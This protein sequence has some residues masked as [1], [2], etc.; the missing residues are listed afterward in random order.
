MALN[1]NNVQFAEKDPSKI[2]NQVITLIES[3]LSEEGEL[4]VKLARSDPRRLLALGFIAG[5][6][7]A[8][9]N[10]DFTG[11]MNLLYYATGDYLDHIGFML[12][13]RRLEATAAVTTLRFELSEVL[14]QAYLIPEGTRATPD[15]KQYFVTE[16]IAE[17]PAGESYIDIPARCMTAG[18]VGNGWLEGQIN[19]LVDRLAWVQK[20]HNTTLSTGGTDTEDDENLRTRI[21][22]AP[23]SFSVAGA[24]GAYEYWA[25]T[26]HQN[27]VDVAVLGPPDTEPGN[28]EIYPLMADGELP[29]QEVLDDVYAVCNAEDVRPMTDYVHVLTPV[30]VTYDIRLAYWIDRSRATQAA[31]IQQTVG[32]AVQDWIRW[33]RSKL[34]RDINPSELNHRM[35]E[36]GAK[37]VDIMSPVFTVLTGSQIAI[38]GEIAVM[39]GGLEDG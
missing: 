7:H 37:R 33:Q 5:L 23:E 16:K 34:G 19:R 30:P 3:F 9:S 6:V 25:R 1:M 13:V 18:Y 29:S 27:I 8:R 14:A 32:Q 31:A 24:R 36:A 21:Q 26:A 35:V 22:I 11:K 2:E 20:V 38:P 17:V 39:F 4:P 12:G 15:G 10:I 28:V